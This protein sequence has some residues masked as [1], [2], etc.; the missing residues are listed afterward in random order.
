MEVCI[1]KKIIAILLAILCMSAARANADDV[2]YIA[3]TMPLTGSD[4][5]QWEV[6]RSVMSMAVDE[7]NAAGG[8]LGRKLHLDCF[9]DAGDPAQGVMII[10]SIV[11][12]PKYVA[13]LGPSYSG[14]T[15]AALPITMAANLPQIT[16]T[17][18]SRITEQGAKNIFINSINDTLM[19]PAAAIYL[20]DT[21]G[22]KTVAVVHNKTTWGQGVSD[23]FTAKAKELGL[24][25]TSSQ[26]IDVDA[27]D[28]SAVLTKIKEEKPDAIY[29]A[30]YTEAGRFRK[31]MV[32]L[33]MT[34]IVFIGAELDGAEIMDAAGE[35]LVGAYTVS[36]APD[37][38]NMNPTTKAFTERCLAS[39]GKK[40]EAWTF[41][42]YDSVY[43]L[44]DAIKRAQST[45]KQKLIDA[46]RTTDMKGV[47]ME[48]FHWSF[49]EKGRMKY[50]VTFIWKCE[51]PG[52]FTQIKKIETTYSD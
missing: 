25:I 19:G 1:M 9:D 7:I 24:T 10:Q 14:V 29:T 44:A 28:Y 46:I 8:V 52:S 17:S 40:P 35:D 12:D 18:N 50:P 47:C 11:D 22:V 20:H 34:D 23:Y 45:D 32:A 4:V 31:Q 30:L 13:L 41:Y 6:Q 27:A 15:L 21:L 48:G 37:R 36:S 2:I 5:Y 3:A 51:K 26:G 43:I 33:G 39:F 38:V 49:D 16:N 42:A